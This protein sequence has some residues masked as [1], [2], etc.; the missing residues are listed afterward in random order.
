MSHHTNWVV[1]CLAALCAAS[2]FADDAVGVRRYRSVAGEDVEFVLPFSPLVRGF[3]DGFL[4]GPFSGDGGAGSDALAHFPQGT[5]DVCY[6][7]RCAESWVDA[8]GGVPAFL[9]AEAGDGLVLTPGESG[10]LDF[11]AFGRL[12]L[13]VPAGLPWFSGM[14]VADDGSVVDLEIAN[15]GSAPVDVLATS[16][17]GEWTHLRRFAAGP[18]GFGWRDSDAGSVL[19]AADE[20]DYLLA[21]A[22]RDTDGDGLPDHLETFVYGTSPHCADTDGDGLSDG[23]E[24]A[25]GSDPLTPGGG[26][27]WRFAE[28]F[29]RPSVVPGPIGG[30]NGW[31]STEA[32]FGEVV[33][34][35]PHGG[36]GALSLGGRG[37]GT[38][39]RHVEAGSDEVWVEAWIKSVRGWP[40]DSETSGMVAFAV[41]NDGHPVATDGGSVAVNAGVVIPDGRWVRVDM[42]LD[43][44]RRTWDCYV[45]GIIAFAGLSMRGAAGSAGELAAV[46]CGGFLDDISVSPERP[47]GLSSDGDLLP[48][49]WEFRHFGT[50]ARD[51]RGDADGDGAPDVVEFRAGTNPLLPDTDFDG[52]TDG[53][54]LA[55]GMDPLA[56]CGS[57]SSFRFFDGFERPSVVPGGL[58]GQNGWSVVGSASAVVQEVVRRSGE[59]ALTLACPEEELA[60]GVSRPLPDGADEVWIDFAAADAAG[61]ARGLANGPEGLGLVTFDND[62][63]PVLTDGDEV[64]TNRAVTA[65][66]GWTRVTLRLDCAGRTWDCYVDGALAGRALALRGTGVRPSDV[67]L[68][69]WGGSVDDFCVSSERPEGLSADGDPLPDE[70][71][72][73][74]LWTLDF[75]G[76]GDSDGD[77]LSDYEEFMSGTDPLRADTDGDGL[78][79]GWEV[80]NGTD[81]FADDAAADPDGDGLD[82]AEEF[83]RGTHPLRADTD[84]DGLPDRWEAG[85]GTDPLVP[86]A[87]ADPDGDG[88]KNLDE[89]RAGGDPFKSDTDGD[90]VDDRTERMELGSDPAVAETIEWVD[91]RTA[92][93]VSNEV[94]FSVETTGVFAVTVAIA[95]E[96]LDYGK[97]KRTPPARNRIGLRLDGHV[98]AFRDFPVELTNVVNVTFFTPVLDT[99]GHGVS[100][101]LGHPEFRL[102]TEVVGVTLA[103]CQ[104]VDLEGV[105]LRRNAVGSPSCASRVSPA[106][107]EGEAQFPWRVSSPAVAV[108]PSGAD[109]WYADVPLSPVEPT[110]AEFTFE[111]AATTN[112]VID[113]I[114]TDLFASPDPI[115][116]RKGSSILVSGLPEGREGGVVEIYTNDVRACSYET[117]GFAVIGFDGAAAYSVVAVWH[118]D[119]TRVESPALVVT[120]VAGGFAAERPA[121]LVGVTRTWQC[122][123]LPGDCAVSGDEH[124]A[125]GWSSR[126]VLNLRVDD[127]RGDRFVTARI[128]EGGAVLDVAQV[129]PLWA[130]A[131]YGNVVYS[132]ETNAYGTLCRAVMAQCGASPSVSFRI[133]SYLSSVLLD[134]LTASRTIGS[135]AFDDNG[136]YAY[137]LIKPA[138]VSAPCHS[139]YIYQG[140]VRIG[141]AVYGNGPMPEEWR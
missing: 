134:D 133:Q 126:G 25:W 53:Q 140:S 66:D 29:E 98:L 38:V 111:G 75:D 101:V 31:S 72:I 37:C 26:S 64:V 42:R 36:C 43:Y 79:D 1:V 132:I 138:S 103:R 125:V 41:D 67:L 40:L 94:A 80:A 49:E 15:D 60:G 62:G 124:T 34:E 122:P 16:P 93:C 109:T 19:R 84:G 12:S 119:E 11:F 48:D 70:W 91:A 5:N 83:R 4:A 129:D 51:G 14:R 123:D 46:G 95:Q 110:V 78:P 63:H 28:G 58:G 27:G 88:L 105:A 2:A 102:H 8:E 74:R 32:G 56:S 137:D 92:E 59:A 82:N 118:D 23:L 24:L 22:S 77:G 81:P 68:L 141:E 7:V 6:A 3:A 65:G 54:E 71:E 127:T 96:W 97:R 61:G 13:S 87:D 108:R 76:F 120:S 69:G 35:G 106:F 18:G 55:W 73:S 107:V 117:N 85:F 39:S 50:L 135:E 47:E 52:Y 20:R 139:V 21:D 90:G 130:V 112:V 30:Q 128:E 136:R 121:C 57:H 86:D 33:S 115:R 99:G 17:S 10:P 114:P 100:V 89:F 44:V 104:G 116:L 131:A 9:D 45:D 113:W